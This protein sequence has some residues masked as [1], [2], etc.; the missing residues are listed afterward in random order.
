MYNH[1][2]MQVDFATLFLFQDAQ[3]SDGSGNDWVQ[4]LKGH[5]DISPSWSSRIEQILLPQLVMAHNLQNYSFVT[6]LRRAFA[7]ACVVAAVEGATGGGGQAGGGNCCEATRG[8]RGEAQEG[9]EEGES[10]QVAAEREGGWGV[11]HRSSAAWRFPSAWCTSP[12]LVG[13][14]KSV[15]LYKIVNTSPST[16]SAEAERFFKFGFML[17]HIV[18]EETYFNMLMRHV[19][20]FKH[21]VTNELNWIK[22][23]FSLS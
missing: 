6:T 20:N 4:R 3:D 1:C 21:L 8:G 15:C 9:A 19:S 10:R 18:C 7:C 23:F 17:M 13:L 12:P 11:G 14:Y 16:A 2:V 22:L 5:A